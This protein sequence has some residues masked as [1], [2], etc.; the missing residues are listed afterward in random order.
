[1]NWHLDV[2][3]WWTRFSKCLT[4]MDQVSFLFQILFRSMMSLWIQSSLKD[5]RQRNKF[6]LSFLIILMAPEVTM[7]ERSQK[8]NFLI[9][10]QT[11]QWTYLTTSISLR[12]SS[13]AGNALRMTQ[14]PMPSQLS[15]CSSRRSV[16]ESLSF[17]RMMWSYFARYTLILTL[18]R[19]IPWQ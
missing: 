6:W 11:S 2:L 12:C 1:M 3:R 9:T 18:I 7:M 13:P 15:R 16:T 8:R 5:A 19:A 10:T 14:T 17:Q 4:A